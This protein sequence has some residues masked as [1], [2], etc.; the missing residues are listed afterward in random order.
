MTK[1]AR[2]PTDVSSED[3]IWVVATV[4]GS[5]TKHYLSHEPGA[6]CV[7]LPELLRKHRR[8]R[9]ML[10]APWGD[11]VREFV[12]VEIAGNQYW[13]NIMTGSLF[14]ESTGESMTCT[15]LRIDFEAEIKKPKRQREKPV[16]FGDQAF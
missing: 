2:K 14:D 6:F 12:L 4:P 10:A 16:R 13:C 11:A 8:I 7:R 1:P 5:A 9:F 15:T 3:G